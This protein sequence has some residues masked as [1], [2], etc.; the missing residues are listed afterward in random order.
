[1]ESDEDC[2]SL[3]MDE[4][5][6]LQTEILDVKHENTRL[7]DQLHLSEDSIKSL[8]ESHQD[9]SKLQQE[10][11]RLQQFESDCK[12]L[13]KFSKEVLQGCLKSVRK[14]EDFDKD[15]SL[16][17]DQ[18]SAIVEYVWP[19][20]GDQDLKLSDLQEISCSAEVK[21]LRETNTKLKNSLE[22]I[23]EKYKAITFSLEETA[24]ENLSNAQRIQELENQKEH[25][26]IDLASR[27]EEVVEARKQLKEMYALECEKQEIA[28]KLENLQ[29]VFEKTKKELENVKESDDGGEKVKGLMKELEELRNSENL[30][31]LE[32]SSLKT[33]AKQ[34]ISELSICKNSNKELE[35]NVKKLE[36]SLKKTHQELEDMKTERQILQKR[37]M[38]DLKDL[39]AELAKEKSM[40]ELCKMEKEKVMQENRKLQEN[41]RAG[42]KLPPPTHQE[43][44]LVESMAHR[45]AELEKENLN[46]KHKIREIECF[47]VENERL[48]KENDDL[49]L[50]INKLS[51]DMAMMGAQFN[52]YIRTHKS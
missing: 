51:E 5:S 36:D 18:M 3:T 31:N 42:V 21:T 29:N 14:Q 50:E 6:R 40:H 28:A 9:L 22:E 34:A 15:Q 27:E 26:I 52:E 37:S 30:L 7:K 1:M 4:Y 8:K 44:V 24:K 19:K 39:K 11:S 32:Y 17:I 12:K 23:K 16:L 46:L 47:V 41:L 10:L 38:H 35:N 2:I 33:S 25:L 49:R 43:K 48:C 45:V 13:P 20:G